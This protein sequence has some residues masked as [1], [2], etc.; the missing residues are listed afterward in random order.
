MGAVVQCSVGGVSVGEDISAYRKG[1]VHAVVGTPGRVLALIRGRN[2]SSDHLKMLI[3][4][5][6]DEMLSAGFQEDIQEV[7]RWV[8]SSCQVGLFSAT[9]PP[10]TLAITEKFMRDPV[11]IVL[12]RD[13]VTLK[14]IRQY[15]VDVGEDRFKLDC[16]MDLF[17]R[18]S[19][20]Q[21]VIFCNS[22]RR[23][24][25]VA[26]GMAKAGF[27]VGCMHSDLAAHERRKIMDA[28]IVGNIRVLISTDLLAR[29][30][31]VQGVE[32]VVNFDMSRD[33][34]NY[35]HRIGRCGRFGRKGRA[36]NF[37]TA[38][39][40]GLLRDLCEYYC[41]DIEPLPETDD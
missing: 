16:L 1:G 24:D 6:A 8:P 20:S 30:I 36:V 11:K 28:F 40:R 25:W 35:A 23:A 31:D 15:Y 38:N 10:E 5:E 4:D 41:T 39:E 18:V 26:G 17:G 13:E 2:I 27:P 33:F 14:G 3:L 21:C 19:V 22:R 7:L 12:N 34:E 37:I 29:G 9:L 32:Y